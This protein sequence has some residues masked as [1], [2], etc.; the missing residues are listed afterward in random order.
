[1]KKLT[2]RIKITLWYGSLIFLILIIF[3]LFMYTTIS[4]AIYHEE[5]HLLKTHISLVSSLIT[6]EDVEV[7]LNELYEI[8]SLGT[9]ITIYDTNGLLISGGEPQIEIAKLSLTYSKLRNIEIEKTAWLIYDEPV[10][11]EKNIMS[12]IR[13]SRSLQTVGVAL[14][15]L[16][17]IIFSVIPIFMIISIVGGLFLSKRALS[18]I[19][20]ITNTAREIGGGDLSQRLKFPKTEDE[21]GKLAIT[22]DEMLDK[23][24]ASFKREKQFSSDVSHELR[25]PLAI[26][27]SQAEET[28]RSNKRTEEY[29]KAFKNILK[30]SKKMSSMFSQL[31]M[32]SRSEEGKYKAVL[33]NLDLT[34]VIKEVVKNME[35]L[36]KI[37][38]IKI[39]I[40]AD[41]NLKVEVDQTLITRL[42][43]NLID[44]A[45]KYSR[46]DGWIKINL[47]KEKNFAKIIVEDNG[48]G[49]SKEDLP[50]I[51][52]RFY[53]VDKARTGDGLGLGLFMVKWIVDLHKGNIYTYSKQARGTKFIIHLPI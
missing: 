21:V 25:T 6:H 31:V 23:L 53:R 40:N 22:F 2:I 18:P 9:F 26:I 46:K 52:D 34:I 41:K 28:L 10:Y 45:V 3:S 4:R 5:E 39:Y 8:M 7:N 32:L 1:M 12:W 43:I 47:H 50:Y 30:E 24:E 14:S 20:N 29:K 13:G 37:N 11:S 27:S 49:I 51:F 35:S 44:N 17:L 16:R 19:T 15:R 42:F 33:E 48:L 38:G 36:A